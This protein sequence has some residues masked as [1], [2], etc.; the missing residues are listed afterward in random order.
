MDNRK[1]R[2]GTPRGLFLAD[3]DGTLLNS[4]KEVSARSLEAIRSLKQA[5]LAFTIVSGRPPRGLSFLI[6]QL[7]LK[8]PSAA[9]D[10]VATIHPNLTI[11]KQ[12]VLLEETVR[13]TIRLG[14]MYKM[15]YWIYREND[16][17]VRNRDAPHVKKEESNVRFSPL[18]VG[19][20]ENLQ[21]Q[22]N[23]IVIVSDE[24]EQLEAIQRE[25]QGGLSQGASSSFSQDFYVDV[26][27]A[28]ANKGSVV[29]D[30]CESLGIPPASVVSIGDMPN[31]ILMFKKSGFSI[32][33]GNAAAEVKRAANYTTDSNDDEG[34]AKAVEYFLKN[35]IYS[36]GTAA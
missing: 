21:D 31:D 26:T 17:Y 22:V 8:L 24:R 5:G 27:P 32:A 4:K 1:S 10:G 25:L 35:R 15:D 28:D 23:K 34:F 19:G 7:G 11:E 9:F 18:V 33:M 29:D 36:Q 6:Q 20:F 12:R 13:K 14:E 3:V 30:L 2:S 16:W